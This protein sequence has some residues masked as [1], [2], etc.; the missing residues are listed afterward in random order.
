MKD[1]DFLRL[2]RHE[3]WALLEAATGRSRTYFLR[4]GPDSI[5]GLSGPERALV[6]RWTEARHR[7]RPLAYLLGFREF[8]GHRFWVNDH[9]LIPRAETEC[10]VDLAGR[11]LA[12]LQRPR[13]RLLDLGTGSGC[14][15]I[16]ILKAATSGI[17]V[18]AVATDVSAGA[19]AT[20]RNNACW[21]GVPV[22]FQAG[23]W[24]DAFNLSPTAPDDHRPEAF[25]LIVSN[26]PYVALDDPDLDASV[27]RH[28]PRAALSGTTPN[29]D[30]LSELTA[31]ISRAS[32]HLRPGGYLLLEHGWR[33]Q[34][35]VMTLC[36]EAGFTEVAGFPDLSGRPRLVQARL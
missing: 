33:Q 8:Y 23:S 29:H 22:R 17:E 16:S 5:A 18:E 14:I 24:F 15:V 26:P 28:E 6:R 4:E 36:R 1:P 19:L 35:A 2:P 13:A 27:R 25:D 7:G 32:A 11:S 12:A 21:H 3:Q 10:L 30:G 20:A 9:V 34:A 31:I